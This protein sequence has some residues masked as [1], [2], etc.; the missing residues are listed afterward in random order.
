MMQRFQHH[1][2][3]ISSLKMCHD[4]A[5]KVEGAASSLLILSVYWCSELDLNQHGLA[6]T[7]PST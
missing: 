2:K 3:S 7:T 5:Q 4:W 6:P 1:I